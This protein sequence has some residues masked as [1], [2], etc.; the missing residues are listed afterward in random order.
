MEQLEQLKQ[1]AREHVKASV[2]VKA[3]PEPS[4][5]PASIRIPLERAFLEVNY[6]EFAELKKQIKQLEHESRDTYSPSSTTG[7]GLRMSMLIDFSTLLNQQADKLAK[8]GAYTGLF[9]DL[10]KDRAA[11][12]RAQRKKQKLSE[13]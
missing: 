11:R 8:A 4:D 1:K 2:I 13:E 7:H 3:R 9:D 10:V 5:L 12:L 6:P